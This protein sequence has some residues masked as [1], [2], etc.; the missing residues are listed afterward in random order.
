MLA[1]DLTKEEQLLDTPYYRVFD[2]QEIKK[3]WSE[4]EQKFTKIKQ[5]QS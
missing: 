3:T 2:Y 4:I 5:E 1:Q